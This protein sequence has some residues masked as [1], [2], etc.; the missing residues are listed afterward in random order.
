MPL[1]FTAFMTETF[2]IASPFQ[3]HDGERVLALDS[4]VCVEAPELH[5]MPPESRQVSGWRNWLAES[6]FR[7]G[8]T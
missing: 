7:F 1:Q 8:T 4:S 5:H 2:L 6:S 3:C